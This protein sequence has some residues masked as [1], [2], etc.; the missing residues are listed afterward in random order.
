MTSYYGRPI[1]KEPVWRWLIPAYF[2]TGGVAAGSALLGAGARRRRDHRTAKRAELAALAAVGVSAA[3]L[4]EDLGRP[5]RFYNMLRVAKP[6]SPMNVGSWLLAVFAPAAGIAAL[7]DTLGVFRRAGR[8]A[9]S[10][11]AALAPAVAT[12]TAVLIADTAVPA[13]HEARTE[14]PFVFA[15]GAAAS[16]GSLGVL[17]G[18]GGP[19]RRMAVGGAVLELVADEA[20]LRR[21][22]FLA[23]PYRTGRRCRLLHRA[24][25]GLTT[26]GALMLAMRGGRRREAGLVGG[27]A[28][29]A[30][31]ALERFAIFEAG[32]ESARDPKYVVEPQRARLP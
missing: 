24:G 30:G 26:G 31:A 4:A 18:G 3:F 9:Q 22:G 19:A 16:G 8:V 15:G 32:R 23:E 29:L 14:L 6:T 11:S 21:L 17:L 10:V 7:T 5:A 13:W 2:F 1:L 20:M 25:R 27:T 28:V 12:Y